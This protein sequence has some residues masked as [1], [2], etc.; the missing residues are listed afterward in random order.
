MIQLTFIGP[1][2]EVLYPPETLFSEQD[3]TTICF[4]SLPETVNVGGD[5][6]FSFS[7][8]NTSPK[9]KLPSDSINSADHSIL[10]GVAVFRKVF[11]PTSK[12][13]FDQKSLVIISSHNFTS[14]FM[15]IIRIISATSAIGDPAP[16]ET[17]CTHIAAWPPI[18]VG[19]LDLPFMG[20]GIELDMCVFLYLTESLLNIIPVDLSM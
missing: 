15:N 20:T 13:R 10:H 2:V 8:R 14:L 16:L 7:L 19:R 11:D 4:D 3:I 17:A 5:M 1:E 12:R 18:T 6:F 9:I